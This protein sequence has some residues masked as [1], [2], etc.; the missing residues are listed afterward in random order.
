MLSDD[1]WVLVYRKHMA[2]KWQRLTLQVI[3]W[4]PEH[5]LY[6]RHGCCWPAHHQ[7][8]PVQDMTS[9]YG[10]SDVLDKVASD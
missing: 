1:V 6:L 7:H 5:V 4:Q 9:T 8:S 3:L 10:G 2:A